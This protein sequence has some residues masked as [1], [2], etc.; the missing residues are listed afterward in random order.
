[1]EDKGA[2]VGVGFGGEEV[3]DVVAFVYAF[4]WPDEGVGG[5]LCGGNCL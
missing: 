3:R 4:G 5:E 1:M 2:Y